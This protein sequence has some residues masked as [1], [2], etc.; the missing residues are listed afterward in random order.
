MN[1]YYWIPSA[2][3]FMLILVLYVQTRL[4]PPGRDPAAAEAAHL[5]PA[6]TPSDQQQE[7]YLTPA[8]LYSSADIAANG[9]ITAADKYRGFRA[10]H[11]ANPQAGERIC[12][13]TRTKAN[14]ECRWVIGGRSYQFCCPPCIDEFVRLAKEQPAEIQPPE[15]YVK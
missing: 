8:G 15:H 2:V 12:P 6:P 14:P 4:L 13:V 9:H 10:R 11:D 7:L 1:R 3:L 5:M